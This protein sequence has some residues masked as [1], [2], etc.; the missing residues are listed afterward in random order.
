MNCY[1]ASTSL[2][3]VFIDSCHFDRG[4]LRHLTG[5]KEFLKGVSKE[6]EITRPI[7]K[8]ELEEQNGNV[9]YNVATQSVQDVVIIDE[10][11]IDAATKK[12]IDRKTRDKSR[13]NY[14]DNGYK[15]GE[16]IKFYSSKASNYVSL[17]FKFML[18]IL[19]LDLFLFQI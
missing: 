7:E 11:S 13:L 9:T 8:A 1:V 17:L 14:Q 4:C 6:D 18:M 10:S 15:K 19:F 16:W 3:T 5:E 12:P 2:K